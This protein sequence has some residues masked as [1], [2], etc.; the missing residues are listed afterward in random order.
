MMEFQYYFQIILHVYS[1]NLRRANKSN[2]AVN[3]A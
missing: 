3:R 2:A 1:I